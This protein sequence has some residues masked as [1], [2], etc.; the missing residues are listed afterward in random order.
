MRL[1]AGDAA[2]EFLSGCPSCR[3]RSCCRT[4]SIPAIGHG[5]KRSFGRSRRNS[6]HD[7]RSHS[8]LGLTPDASERSL[9]AY[10]ALGRSSPDMNPGDAHAAEMMN[11][12]NAA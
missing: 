9:R 1:L 7:R 11:K 5:L 3:T 2:E 4:F 8:V 10:R 12:I 6:G